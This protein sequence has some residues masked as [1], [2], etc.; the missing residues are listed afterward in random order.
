[1]AIFSGDKLQ[2]QTHVRL[3]F[4]NSKPNSDGNILA[5]VLSPFK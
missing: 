2:S 4:V 5:G 3:Y 1:M